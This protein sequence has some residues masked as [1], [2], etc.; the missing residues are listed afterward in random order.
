[1]NKTQLAAD[2]AART[3]STPT[4]ARRHVDAVLSSIVE[5]VADGDRVSLVGFGT[6][7]G[8]E[9]PARTARNPQ[10]GASVE[11]PAAV[12][13]RFRAGTGFRTRVSESGNATPAAASPS[14]ATRST[15]K[16]A[17]K[18]ASKAKDEKSGKK[19][20]SKKDSKKKSKKGKKSKKK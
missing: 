12:V 13:P 6:F 10:T 8:A 20:D 14:P 9:R 1:M 4:E 15:S 17:A 3:G 2:V 11:V 7:T 18:S 16:A 5:S 19:K